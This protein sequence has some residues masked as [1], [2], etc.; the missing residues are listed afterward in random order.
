[1]PIF[2]NLNQPCL[3]QGSGTRDA[4]LIAYGRWFISNPDLPQRFALN[5]PLNEY[6][7]STFYGGDATG[8]IDYP[9]LE[10]ESVA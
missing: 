10:L 2:A 7:R 9:A 4:D 3:C 5:A 6:D 1:L 8:Y